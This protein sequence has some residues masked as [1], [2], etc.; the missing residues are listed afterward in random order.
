MRQFSPFAQQLRQQHHI[1]IVHIDRRCVVVDQ[2]V[3]Y[4]DNR[5]RSGAHREMGGLSLQL[6]TTWTVVTLSGI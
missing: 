4:L 5:I 3:R 6:D 2:E 1:Q